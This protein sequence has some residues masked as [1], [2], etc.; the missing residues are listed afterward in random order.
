MSLV[1]VNISKEDNAREI[2][3]V[4][5]RAVLEGSAL[6]SQVFRSQKRKTY[7]TIHYAQYM[8]P[9]IS[10]HAS[11]KQSTERYHIS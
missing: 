6:K 4:V 2:Y 5:R 10:T 11:F 3:R 9:H 7:G 8:L 1:F